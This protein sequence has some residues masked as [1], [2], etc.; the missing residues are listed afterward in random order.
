M[1]TNAKKVMDLRLQEEECLSNNVYFGLFALKTEHK[2]TPEFEEIFQKDLFLRK[3]VVAL[4]HVFHFLFTIYNP[5]EFKK[6]FY[7]PLNNDR[8]AEKIFRTSCLTYLLELNEQFNLGMD[9][10]STYLLLF[11]GGLKFLRVLEKFIKFIMVEDLKKTGDE[12]HIETMSIAQGNES[13]RILAAK[14]NA[15]D[16][17]AAEKFRFTSEEQK[18]LDEIGRSQRGTMER[19][20]SQFNVLPN[21]FLSKEFRLMLASKATDKLQIFSDH[22]NNLSDYERIVESLADAIKC[23]E[24]PLISNEL[25]QKTEEVAM[26][27]LRQTP[28]IKENN[29]FQIGNKVNVNFVL[30]LTNEVLPNFCAILRKEEERRDST[31][32]EDIETIDSLSEEIEGFVKKLE[33]NGS[34]VLEKTIEDFSEPSDIPTNTP[35]FRFAGEITDIPPGGRIMYHDDRNH[36]LNQWLLKKNLA[37]STNSLLSST[38]SASTFSTIRK[39][40]SKDFMGKNLAMSVIALTKTGTKSKL[41]NKSV[42]PSGLRWRK[43]RLDTSCMSSPDRDLSTQTSKMSIDG[44][45]PL[46]SSSMIAG[47][48]RD[49]EN[50]DNSTKYKY[51]PTKA[52]N[53]FFNLNVSPSGRLSNVAA[54]PEAL[55]TVPKLVVSEGIPEEDCESSFKDLLKRIPETDN[56]SL[57]NTS[58][59]VLKDLEI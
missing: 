40:A 1:T 4:P 56:D 13:L 37:R 38:R 18:K 46:G 27:I 41:L 31:F 39:T 58:D 50:A 12:K 57:F 19:L 35:G 23:V 24:K 33:E 44:H 6:R 25:I 11:P 53:Q 20:A 52:L 29:T 7:W 22:Q 10:L 14:K 55:F 15:I 21:E 32:R 3:N 49:L 47:H 17:I 59:G 28:D 48:D 45:L 51:T 36:Y 30:K 8:N 34:E 16:K 43:E 9:D 26:E 54:S 5:D 42:N 2:P